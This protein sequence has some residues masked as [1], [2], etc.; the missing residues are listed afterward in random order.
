MMNVYKVPLHS[1]VS[2]KELRSKDG[3][4]A[5]THKADFIINQGKRTFCVEVELSTKS[6]DR[7]MNNIKQNYMAY[8]GQIWTVPQGKVKIRD[9]LAEASELYSN[10]RII[11]MEVIDDYIRQRCN[12]EQII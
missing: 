5:R 1:I 6:K 8:S 2:E 3:F 9:I 12:P 4:T 7:L 11:D 10:I